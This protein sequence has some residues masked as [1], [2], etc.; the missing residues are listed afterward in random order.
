MPGLG[1]AVRDTAN[2]SIV[3]NLK[4]MGQPTEI[5]NKPAI[6]LPLRVSDGSVY[7][8]MIPLGE[9]PPLF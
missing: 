2:S 1:N 7:L 4:K 3:D 6:V 8:G 5:D 9:L